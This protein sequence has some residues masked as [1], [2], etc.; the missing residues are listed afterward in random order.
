MPAFNHPVRIRP[1]EVRMNESH[2]EM[3][4][5]FCLSDLSSFEQRLRSIGASLIQPRTFETNLRFDT[6]NLEL[7]KAH[8]VLR[9]RRDQGYYL[10]YKGPAQFGKTVSIRQEVEVEVSDFESTEALLQAL[11]YQV[12]VRYE[13]WRT[14]Y[15]L[16]DIEIDLDEMPFGKFIEIEGVDPVQIEHMARTLALDWNLRI[17][18]SYMMLF[19][20]LKKNKHIEIPNLVFADLKEIKIRPEDLG[21]KPAD[22]IAYL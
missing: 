5:K 4:V 21:V 16:N 18:D 7:T 8:R 20:R 9:L 15:N 12:S 1:Q 13:K 22:I 11:G 10:T 2:L 6:A 3:E 19:D 14:K 17:T